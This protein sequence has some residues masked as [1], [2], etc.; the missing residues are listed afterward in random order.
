MHTEE[1]N[2]GSKYQPYFDLLDTMQSGMNMYGAPAKLRELF[3]E[4]PRR[5][6]MDIT[7]AWMK[8]KVEGK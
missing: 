6:A 2:K 4:L 5:E 1:N 3:P 8:S 7:V